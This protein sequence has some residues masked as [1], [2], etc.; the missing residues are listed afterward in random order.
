MT[1]TELLI[2]GWREWVSL[3]GL[4]IGEI[5]AKI[6][7]GAR[8]SSLHA[9]D[10]QILDLKGKQRVRFKLH[11]IQRNTINTVSAEVDLI[12][13]RTVRNSGGHT[14]LRPVILT[15]MELMG[16]QWLIELTLTNRDVMG[17]RMLLGRQAIKGRFLIDCHQ[18]FLSNS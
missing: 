11:P 13:Y 17:F 18:S 15:D 1:K 9:F 14:E 3:P 6:D 7:T 4:G 16:K 2:I 8:S 5:K 12:E 10:I